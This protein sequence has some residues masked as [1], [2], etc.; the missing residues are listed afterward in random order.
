[1]RSLEFALPLLVVV[2][3]AGNPDGV[4]VD[5]APATV[6]SLDATTTMTA[7]VVAG[8][9]PLSDEDVTISVKYTDRNGTDHSL[10]DTKAKTDA[11]GAVSS[12]LDGLLWDGT[13]TVTVTTGNMISG[14]AT[15]AVLDRTPPKIEILPPTTDNKVGAGLPVDVQVKVSD[16]IGISEVLF[17]GTGGTQVSRRTF[18][19]SGTQMATLTFRIDVPPNP[20][21]NMIELHALAADLSGN[22]AAAAALTLTVD[23]TITIA[24]PPGLTGSLLTDGT[25]AQ[26]VNPTAVAMS[27]KDNQLYVTDIAN[28]TG[29]TPSCVW[30]VDPTSGMVVTKA[31]TGLGQLSGIAFDATG[32]NMYVSDRTN[33]VRRFAWDTVAL[34]Y[35]T[36]AADCV[37]SGAQLPQTPYH[38]IFDGARILVVDDQNRNLQTVA[39]TCLATNSGVALT[40]QNSFD[41][42]RGV[43][44]GA[45]AADLFVSDNG[46]DRV[47]KVNATTGAR[48]PFANSNA[49]FG[50]EWLA[51]GTSAFKDSLMIASQGDRVVESSTGTG[52]SVAAAYLRNT[53]I[54]LAI[55]GMTMY[56]LT[57]PS[58][59]NRGRIYKVTGF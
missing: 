53:P 50:I 47:F 17:D 27:P 23:P 58:A 59:N 16:E 55:S 42:P 33:H 37:N 52:P 21:N 19:A 11:R 57:Q 40:T 32:D 6:S 35:S 13:G 51:G 49:P 26:M 28:V 31:E 8:S 20:P 7:L 29:C 4:Q 18:I 48:T 9:T 2:G 12:K 34:A 39:A 56:V 3:C 10:P 43:A 1:M 25:A 14:S 38:L 46:A 54:D 41:T 44:M 36:T 5:L 30:K 45:T 24:T 22:L 15:F